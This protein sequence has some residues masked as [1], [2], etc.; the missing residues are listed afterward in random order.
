[1]PARLDL[2]T[3]PAESVILCGDPRRAFHLA[4]ELVE[5][6][7]MTHLARG[8]WGYGG[9]TDDGMALTVQSTGAGGPAAIAVLSGLAEHGIGKVVRVGSCTAEVPELGLGDRLVVEAALAEDGSQAFFTDEVDD[10]RLPDRE[11]TEALTGAGPLAKIASRY[12]TE[13][14][15]REG[16]RP[17]VAFDLQTAALLAAAQE[18]GVRAAAV[19]VVSGTAGGSIGSEEEL[20]AS[21]VEAGRGAIGALRA[22]R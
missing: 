9:R 18:A 14:P 17:A 7:R 21:F 19:L 3:K 16:D 6:P 10:W 1:M 22:V 8:L 11:L 20:A 2:T 15:E 13:P 12:R 4:Q 5:E